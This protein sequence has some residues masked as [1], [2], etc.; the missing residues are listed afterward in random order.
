[1]SQTKA[2]AAKAMKTIRERHGE[3]FHREAGR[4]GG[5]VLGTQGG[6]ASMTPDEHRK[7]SSKGGTKSRRGVSKRS[8]IERPSWNRN[9]LST[10][11]TTKT[12]RNC[13]THRVVYK[14]GF[15]Q[16]CFKALGK[17]GRE[18]VA[19]TEAIDRGERLNEYVTV[20]V[21]VDKPFWHRWFK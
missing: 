12:C 17:L 5:S 1:M 7:A 14:Q 19:E 4:K 6:F 3:N 15:C 10:D 8:N 18:L 9:S 21:T 16:I 20:P 13:G 11:S 2:G